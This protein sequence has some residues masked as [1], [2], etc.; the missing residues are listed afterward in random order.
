MDIYTQFEKYSINH[1]V[2]T[3]FQLNFFYFF[4]CS[5]FHFV[6]LIKYFKTC[7]YLRIF[8]FIKILIPIENDNFLISHDEYTHNSNELFIF[9]YEEHTRQT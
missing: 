9:L 6:L 3:S 8:L 7:K 2:C 1:T 4:F 5:F